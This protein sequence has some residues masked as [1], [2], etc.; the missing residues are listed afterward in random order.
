M[1]QNHHKNQNNCLSTWSQKFWIESEKNCRLCLR[2]TQLVISYPFNTCLCSR[3]YGMYQVVTVKVLTHNLKQTISKIKQHDWQ[4]TTLH[5]FY[6]TRYCTCLVWNPW[7]NKRWTHSRTSFQYLLNKK[8]VKKSLGTVR[9]E[10]ETS[11]KQRFFD[12]LI[13]YYVLP[14][15]TTITLGII[16]KVNFEQKRI[17]AYCT[18]H[19]APLTSRVYFSKVAWRKRF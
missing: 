1:K 9:A 10:N 15:T 19:H 12:G 5:Y 7:G 11:A 18:Y 17:K 3:L 16:S 6:S 8:I 14:H 4:K 13:Y 2:N